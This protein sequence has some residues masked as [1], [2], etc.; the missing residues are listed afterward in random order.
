MKIFNAINYTNLFKHVHDK[1]YKGIVG[2]E[3][4]NFS[5]GKEGEMA[6]IEAYAKVDS[7]KVQHF[8]YG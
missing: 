6:L 1:G 7:F 3:H 4:G 8:E 2:M 5:P